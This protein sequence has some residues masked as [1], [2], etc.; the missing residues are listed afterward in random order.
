MK[1]HREQRT[2]DIYTRIW[3][4]SPTTLDS[5]AFRLGIIDGI[6]PHYSRRQKRIR[7]SRGESCNGCSQKHASG[8]LGAATRCKRM[9]EGAWLLKASCFRDWRET[10]RRPRSKALWLCAC[11]P[12]PTP[13][14]GSNESGQCRPS[15]GRSKDLCYRVEDV[16][17]CD[18]AAV[19]S[20]PW[21][22]LR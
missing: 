17:G 16:A 4:L 20:P 13:M 21:R 22:Q 11:A 5:P 12:K 14:R 15:N 1:P 2:E 8:H 9:T 19:R 6:V 10:L 18:N 3:E 7:C